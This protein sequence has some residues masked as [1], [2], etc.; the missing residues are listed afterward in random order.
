MYNALFEYLN[1]LSMECGVALWLAAV[2]DSVVIM[3]GSGGSCRGIAIVVRGARLV[4][5]SQSLVNKTR[6]LHNDST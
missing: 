4:C 5:Y 3:S 1:S 2:G 6:E